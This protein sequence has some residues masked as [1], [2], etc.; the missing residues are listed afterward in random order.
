M[1]NAGIARQEELRLSMSEII[2]DVQNKTYLTGLS[3]ADGENHRQVAQMQANNDDSNLNQI[4]RSVQTALGNLYQELG[5]WVVSERV[6]ASNLQLPDPSGTVVIKVE[7][8]ANFNSSMARGLVDASH[9]YIVAFA[10]AEWFVITNKADAPQYTSIAVEALKT[11]GKAMS[12][13]TRPS[14]PTDTVKQPASE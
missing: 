4:L 5:E 8:P 13:R 3:R 12:R 6:L 1:D 11:V 7:Y 2:Y 9:Q 14:R 10:V